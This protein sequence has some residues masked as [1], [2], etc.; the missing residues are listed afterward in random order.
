M[1]YCYLWAKHNSGKYIVRIE[2]TDRSRFVEGSID[3]IFDIHAKLGISID[4][5]IEH[6]GPHGPYIQSQRLDTYAPRL[7]KL[8][9]EGTAYYCF[10]TPERLDALKKEQQALKLPPRYDGH[11]RH[12]P[13]DEARERIAQ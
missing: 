11:C 10:C 13:L 2:D 4:E 5:S 6:G 3:K 9:D 12:I 1:L 8:C 7:H